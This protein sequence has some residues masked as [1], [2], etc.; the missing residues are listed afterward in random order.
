MYIKGILFYKSLFCFL[1]IFKMNIVEYFTEF[2]LTFDYNIFYI[3]HK[4]LKFFI[5]KFNNNKVYLLQKT[6]KI[7]KLKIKK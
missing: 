6:E 5:K 2:F 1:D 3:F 4:L 7:N